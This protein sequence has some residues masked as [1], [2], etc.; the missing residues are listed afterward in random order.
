MVVAYL[1][2]IGLDR[3]LCVMCFLVHLKPL[4]S[5]AWAETLHFVVVHS[6]FFH[7]DVWSCM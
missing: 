7:S 2:V 5:E 3:V 1:L 6:A 4:H